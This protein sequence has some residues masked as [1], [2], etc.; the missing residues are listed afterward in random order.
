MFSLR[1][2]CCGDGPH[3]IWKGWKQP[4]FD[5]E[6]RLIWLGSIDSV[7]DNGQQYKGVDASTVGSWKT[8]RH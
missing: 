4:H 2:V 1:Y 5:L 8:N 3:N 6:T 7:L